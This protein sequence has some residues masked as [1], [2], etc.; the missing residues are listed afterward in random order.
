MEGTI[1]QRDASLLKKEER[2]K[3][4]KLS[5]VLL[6]QE[7]KLKT[8]SVDRLQ[9]DRAS[10][11]RPSNNQDQVQDTAYIKHED[12]TS[13]AQGLDLGPNESTTRDRREP[14]LVSRKLRS[15]SMTGASTPSSQQAKRP[16][17]GDSN[18]VQGASSVDDDVLNI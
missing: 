1:A 13:R 10:A 14:D 15:L 9:A 17:L 3:E 12:I 6:Q 4:L 7:L 2:I 18:A 5:V 8:Q 11:T 16:V